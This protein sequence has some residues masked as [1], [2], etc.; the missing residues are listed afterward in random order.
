MKKKIDIGSLQIGMYLEADVKESA[1][2]KAEKKSNALLLGKGVLVTSETQIR[3][4]KEAGMTE[5]TIDTSKGKDAA[6][7]V[8]VEPVKSELPREKR[9][10]PLLG[11]LM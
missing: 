5:V 9:E 1:K 4:L 8:S 11:I 7:G 2:E 10:K 6:G 3:R